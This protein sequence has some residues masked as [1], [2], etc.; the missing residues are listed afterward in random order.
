MYDEV[1]VPDALAAERT[2]LA[3]ERTFLAYVRTAFAMFVAGI[4]GGQ[5]LKDPIWSLVAYGL[6]VLGVVVFGVGVVRHWDS[7]RKTQRLLERLK[8]R[9]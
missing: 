4:T 6:S 8:V 3:A 9:R 5:L 2:L 7:R 1:P